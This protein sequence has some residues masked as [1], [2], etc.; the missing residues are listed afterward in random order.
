MKIAFHVHTLSKGGAERA[1]TNLAEYF[2]KKG[3]DVTIITSIKSES[4]YKLS[5]LVKRKNLSNVRK[6]SFYFRYIVLSYKLR[7]ICI[8]DKYDV[9][10][11]FMSG[12]TL[13]SY[14]ATRGQ[15]TLLV[16]SVRNDPNY[17]YKGLFGYLVAKIIM[18]SL[19]GCVFQTIE[20]MKWF[21]NK[22]QKKSTV[23]PNSINPIFYGVERTPIPNRVVNIGRLSRQKNQALLIRAF[24]KVHQQLA[25][26]ELYIY[27]KGEIYQELKQLILDLG[28]S[29]YVFLEGEN[30]NIRDVLS[31]ADI[32]VLSSDFEGMPNALLEAMAVGVPCISTDCPCGGPKELIIND[33]NGMLFPVGDEETLSKL[34]VSL[35][36]DDKKKRLFSKNSIA[37]SLELTEE[38]I[39]N[40]WILYID[41][42][43]NN[44]TVP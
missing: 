33:Y 11:S 41:K 38:K 36:F 37:K 12:S 14:F 20:A 31:K 3:N 15:R 40:I 5:D 30:S 4:E 32:F 26:S 8:Y 7:K 18:P 22:L 25:N 1:V 39:G 27:G 2:A 13:R 42:I 6:T 29:D 24:R 9:I 10:I 21:P 19:D 44:T 43:L 17:E 23:I 16:S 35:L 28:V 34:I